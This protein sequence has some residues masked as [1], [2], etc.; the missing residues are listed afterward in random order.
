MNSPTVKTRYLL[1]VLLLLTASCL[2]MK[3]IA[4]G[5][6]LRILYSNDNGGELE[7]CG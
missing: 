4:A 5:T 2:S 6:D 1:L 7:S 3:A